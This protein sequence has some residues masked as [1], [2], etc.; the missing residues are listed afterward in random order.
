MNG[1]NGHDMITVLYKI[2]NSESDRSGGLYNAFQMPKGGGTTLL[3]VKQHCTA[4]NR[5]N[6]LGAEGYHWRVCIEDKQPPSSS[7]KHPFSWW[8]VQDEKARLPVKEFSMSQVE[9]MFMNTSISAE[10][11]LEASP[12]SKSTAKA[13]TKG[14]G[15]AM[16]AVAHAVEGTSATDSGPR[17]PIIAFKLLDLVKTHDDFAQ[18]H[19][20]NSEHFPT[21]VARAPKPRRSPAPPAAARAQSATRTPSAVHNNQNHQHRQVNSA[22]PSRTAAPV[23]PP[24]GRAAP[25]QTPTSN[26]MDFG[27]PAPVAASPAAS[28]S[29]SSFKNETRAERLKREYAQK[30]QKANRVWDDV[31]QRWVEV[32]AKAGVKQGT[33]SAPPHPSTQSASKKVVGI[34]L[35]A[36]NAVGKSATVQ[37]AVHSRVNE[38]KQSQ[39]KAVEEVR[40]REMKKQSAELEEDEVRKRLEPMIKKW[41]EEHGKKKQLRALLASLHTILWPGAN[42]KQM[43]IGDL[44]DDSKVK[45]AF[46]KAS[47]VVHPDKTGDLDAEKRFLAKRIFDALSQAKTEFDEGAK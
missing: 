39:Q 3:S 18:K 15:K 40:Q 8:D 35:D 17:V 16:N 14:L 20:G 45:R 26:L 22:Q 19:G 7:S 43:S 12:S 27:A 10:A 30:Q 46:H 41:S 5:L 28:M 1:Y 38:M 31:D 9:S 33:Q 11:P 47:R 32:D 29:S 44:L 24:A 6:H 37:A 4:L 13:F 2:V 42:W 36:S 21:G 23:R 34:K 25:N